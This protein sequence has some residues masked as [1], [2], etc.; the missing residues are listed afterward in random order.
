MILRESKPKGKGKGGRRQL[1]WP[2]TLP[3]AQPANGMMFALDLRMI[4]SLQ[5]PD[6]VPT[7]PVPSSSVRYRPAPDTSGLPAKRVR[8]VVRQ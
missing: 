3:A 1:V 6:P 5:Y 4:A 8:R 2:S 7:P